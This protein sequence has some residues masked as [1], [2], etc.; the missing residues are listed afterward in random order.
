MLLMGVPEQGHGAGHTDGLRAA[1]GLA[2][3]QRFAGGLQQ[4][5]R[6][7]AQG[8]DLT[9]IEH[10]QLLLP[11]IPVHQKTTTGQ[12]GT[13]RFHH[14]Q[15]RLGAHQGIHCRTTGLEHSHSGPAGA[16]VGGDDRRSPCGV[17]DGGLAGIGRFRVVAAHRW[18]GCAVAADAEAKDQQQ[19]TQHRCSGY[20]ARTNP[21]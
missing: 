19:G 16:G 3:G 17:G 5:I 11:G 21:P 18:G 1:G 10:L 8:S 9:A 20:G 14:G 7:A 4:I 13:L 2:P 12:A 15:Y 6:T